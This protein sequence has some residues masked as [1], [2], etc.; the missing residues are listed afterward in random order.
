MLSFVSVMYAEESSPKGISLSWIHDSGAAVVKQP[1]GGGLT[2][3]ASAVNV[4]T[5]GN[6]IYAAYMSTDTVTVRSFSP[7]GILNWRQDFDAAQVTPFLAVSRDGNTY[8][9]FHKVTPSGVSVHVYAINN[10]SGEIRWERMFNSPCSVSVR[11]VDGVNVYCRTGGALYSGDSSLTAIDSNGEELGSL[12][13]SGELKGPGFSSVTIPGLNSPD[14]EVAPGWLVSIQQDTFSVYSEYGQRVYTVPSE[15][16]AELNANP[17]LIGYYV[18]DDGS[19]LLRSDTQSRYYDQDGQLQWTR[20]FGR[21]SNFVFALSRLYYY[22]NNSNNLHKISRA[23]GSDELTFTADRNMTKVYFDKAASISGTADGGVIFAGTQSYWTTAL[24]PDTM[25]PLI[26]FPVEISADSAKSAAAGLVSEHNAKL[27]PDNIYTASFPS[28]IDFERKQLYYL[29]AFGDGKL[30]STIFGLFSA[31]LP[32]ADA[33][34]HP[35][36][37][38]LL[39]LYR[40]GVISIPSD[41]LIRPDEPLTKEQFIAMLTRAAKV[42]GQ[43]K[44]PTFT[45]VQQD[46]WSY[47]LIEK[48]VVLRILDKGEGKLNPEKLITS[49][50][51]AAMAGKGA[52]LLKLPAFSPKPVVYSDDEYIAAATNANFLDGIAL[53]DKNKNITKAEA[54]SIIVRFMD[55]RDS[56]RAAKP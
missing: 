38:D 24:E 22:D 56:Q 7:E 8:I 54:A 45:D 14:T 32:F 11:N 16:I 12:M 27:D 44:G 50:E 52:Q 6:V 18:F 4:D 23:D 51:C 35:G 5:D 1:F 53:F 13:I 25:K 29:S 43:Y 20:A 46:R 36:A 9:Y 28:A 26:R 10:S 41:G 2:A 48:A 17:W 40:E 19:M 31:K 42:G 30:D 15:D 33:A 39:R 37:Q 47:Y 34:N 49:G 21:Q 55:Y 3:N